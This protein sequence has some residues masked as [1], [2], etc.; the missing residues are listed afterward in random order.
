MRYAGTGNFPEPVLE[1]VIP[2]EVLHTVFASHFRRPL[3]R[4]ADE[5]AATYEEA[6]AEKRPTR[7]L[8][9]EIVGTERQIPIR[10]LLVMQNY[11]DNLGGIAVLYAQ[12][13]YLAEYLIDR[14]GKQEFVRFWILPIRRTGIPRFTP[15]MVSKTRRRHILQPGRNII[16]STSKL[17]AYTKSKCLPVRT[18]ASVKRIAGPFYLNCALED[19]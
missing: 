2:H 10:R 12:G 1:S 13:F 16:R 4:W 5:G 18:A 3:P 17:P 14:E 19:W 7:E 9:R 15:T 8:A 6:E 11:P